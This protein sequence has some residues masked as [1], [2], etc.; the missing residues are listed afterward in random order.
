MSAAF[1]TSAIEVAASPPAFRTSSTAAALTSK[2]CTGAP[3]FLATLQHIG[4]I[5]GTTSVVQAGNLSDLGNSSG[6]GGGNVN[7]FFRRLCPAG[8]AVKGVRV[9]SGSIP[10]S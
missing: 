2:A 10:I 4:P 9:R 5:C 1:A 8:H 6:T 7:H 3:C